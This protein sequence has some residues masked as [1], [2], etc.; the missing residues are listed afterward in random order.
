MKR[1]IIIIFAG[2]LLAASCGKEPQP[3]PSPGPTPTP[4]PSN[5]TISGTVV[6][7]DG[8][9]L[10]GVVVSDGLNCVK[11]G[12][13]GTFYLASDLEN[14]DYVFV[15]TPKDYAAPVVNGIA[16]F[17]KFLRDLPQSGGKY[18]D[19]KFT[20]NKIANPDRFSMVIY[21]DPQPRATG[22]GYDRLAYHSLDCCDD[23]YRDMKEYVQGQG[24]RKIYGMGLGDI[25]H[26]AMDL[27]PR[28][29]NG[30]ESTGIA[31]YSVLGNHDHDPKNTVG[32]RD[33]ART[34]ESH[35]GP[36][37]YSF[38]IGDYH[39]ICVDNMIVTKFN[40]DGTVSDDCATGL[41]DDIWKWVQNDLAL[42]PETAPLMICAHSPMFRRSGGVETKGTHLADLRALVSRHPSVLHWAGHHHSSFNYAGDPVIESHTVTRVTG[43]LW[44][45]EYIGSNGTPRGYIILDYDAGD[46]K[47]KFK[48]I[49]YQTGAFTG[50]NGGGGK[51]PEY[52]YRDWDYDAS[53]RA[54]MRATGKPLDDSYQMQVFGPD[55]YGDG[56]LYVNVFLWDE[57]WGK[58]KF[59]HDGSLQPMTLVTD[60]TKKFP[61]CYKEIREFYKANNSVLAGA[62]YSFSAN[63]TDSMF[64]VFV[65]EL[66][67][68]GTVSV[69]DR[70]GNTFTSVVTW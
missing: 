53:G 44:T 15:S 69:N 12:S 46:V 61:W 26:R 38:N 22:A 54:I 41:T 25:V 50:T 35:M 3:S 62:D 65:S 28:Y 45:N 33:A 34:F 60:K 56:Y 37:N 39:I 8:K 32:D 48:P 2:L 59:A 36:V 57:K 17:W 4:T 43:E 51:Q 10:A 31:T 40:D 14:T 7:S 63:S 18:K 9:A 42:V 66:H 1:Y 47:W 5:A 13:D 27:L 21:G 11:T 49:Y 68:S 70:F 16:V 24:D 55:V 58:P 23:M 29:K 6:G 64:R 67:G 19:V 52:K 20:L 30:M